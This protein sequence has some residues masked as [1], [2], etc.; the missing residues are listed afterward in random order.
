[1]RHFPVIGSDIDATRV[2]ELARGTDQT[3][4]V[5]EEEF[6]GAKQISYSADPQDLR[7]C[8][9]FVPSERRG[10]AAMVMTI[11]SDRPELFMCGKFSRAD[12]IRRC[13]P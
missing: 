7:A 9:F 4:E 3:H 8:N 6:P 11:G 1:M 5:T 10:I 2:D 13:S 12:F